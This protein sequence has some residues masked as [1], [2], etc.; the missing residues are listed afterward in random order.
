MKNPSTGIRRIA[1]ISLLTYLVM[2]TPAGAVI[3]G[4]TLGTGNN[5]EGEAGLQ[6]YLSSDSYPA[7][8][9]FGNLVRVSDASGIYLGYNPSTMVGWVLSANHITPEPTS[10]TVGGSSYTVT[11]TGT[12]IGTTDL[13]LYQIGGLGDPVL[14]T[15]PS[16]P[17]ASTF[18]VT[19]EFL[20]MTGR[21]F[22]T[23]SSY[24]Y[25]WGSP[26]FSDLATNRWAT[27][28]VEFN[29]LVSGNPYIVTDF[30]SPL[31]P[32]VTAYEGQASLGDSGGGMFILRGG[33]WILAGVAHFV[34][35]GPDFLI[36]PSTGTNPTEY[37]D[38]SAY[39]DIASNVAA[40]NAVTGTLV[41][42]PSSVLIVSLSGAGMLLR[43]RRC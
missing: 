21:G 13:I 27:N 26:G 17:L 11:G 6:G 33:E 2:L 28:T 41:P 24:P 20:L 7:F 9:Y 37:G 40:I 32:L 10:I 22:T 5:N 12:Q 31:N 42:E 38:Y 29:A 36:T 23:S 18:A 25:P 14:P 19:G 4:G 35:D 30:D 1:G 43:R 3:V 34:D 16:V 15:L 39:S 8:D